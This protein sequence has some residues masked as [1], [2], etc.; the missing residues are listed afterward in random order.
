MSQ[1]NLFHFHVAEYPLSSESVPY[2]LNPDGKDLAQREAR[3]L[4]I[5]DEQEVAEEVAE[6]LE[7][8]GFI[9]LIAASAKSGLKLFHDMPSI[10]IVISDIRMPEVGGLDLCRAIREGKPADRDV[11]ILLMTGHAG[12]PEAIEALKIGALD[13]LTK[14]LSP[15]MLSHAVKR[16][17]QHIQALALERRFK[18]KL[19]AEVASKTRELQEKANELEKINTKLVI[20][21]QI[22]SEFLAMISH[23]F[24]TPLHQIIGFADI[25]EMKLTDP[26]QSECIKQLS[27]AA[28]RLTEMF[29]SIL[30]IIAVE[31]RTLNLNLY[32]VGIP[33]VIEQASSS[34]Q[35]KARK[36][37]VTIVA[38]EVPDS[39]V[40]I[41]GRRVS[42]A[43][44]RL[45][46]NAIKFSPIG[47]SVRISA[48]QSKAAL[49]ISVQD[50]GPGMT[51]RD[52]KIALQTFRQVDGSSTRMCEGI[53]IGLPLARMLAELHGGSLAIQSIP[54]QGTTVTLTV[55]IEWA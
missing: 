13:F 22:K 51:K 46:D 29:N 26:G 7:M 33:E 37:G 11:A 39:L 28:W 40:R 21:N 55:P 15:V 47:G 45:I 42:Q 4:I 23:E 52:Q 34:Y 36:S 10:S 49:V 54:R 3:V 30:D 18:E 6:S 16:A 31:T 5:D 19:Q 48:R 43:L 20:A 2:D 38:S 35:S 27:K 53:G 24:R 44:G 1:S 25:I 8:K 32:Q 12:L 41:D 17:D 9:C 50:D 14:P